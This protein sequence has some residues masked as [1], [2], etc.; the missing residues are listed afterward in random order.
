MKFKE[1]LRLQRKKKGISQGKLADIAGVT[2]GSIAN[3]EQ[4]VSYPKNR[5][6][7]TRLAEYFGVDINYFLTEDEDEIFL[8]VAMERFGKEGLTKAQVLLKETAA[9]F[10]GGEL[11]ERDKIA[12]QREMQGI[13]LDSMSMS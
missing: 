7:Y 12:F 6:V 3:Y 5:D 2:R 4:G 13:F 9:L 1:K 10:A 8:A 11:S